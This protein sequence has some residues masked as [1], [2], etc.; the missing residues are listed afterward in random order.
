MKKVLGLL[1]L[2]IFITSGCSKTEK[3][4]CKKEETTDVYKLN[5]TA[6]ISIKKDL[7]SDV[8]M[9]LV[10]DI[11]AVATEMCNILKENNS[12][13]DC[14][15]N[16]IIIKDYQKSISEETLNKEEIKTYFESQEYIC[17]E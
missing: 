7:V 4:I 5:T 12:S 16:E 8:K 13:I 11:S 6:T 10:Y 3:I 15:D 17:E 9:S 2:T 1:V 14:K